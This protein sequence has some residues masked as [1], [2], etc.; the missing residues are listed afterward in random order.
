MF[1]Q[2]CPF[3]LRNNKNMLTNIFASNVAV[4]V[5]SFGR[6][7]KANVMFDSVYT[8]IQRNLCS[9][10]LK[11]GALLFMTNEKGAFVNKSNSVSNRA[12][13]SMFE[14]DPAK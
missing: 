10:S 12:N 11:L 14:N 9:T 5:V 2:F 7:R 4:W 8:W 3:L 13:I 6:G 1:F